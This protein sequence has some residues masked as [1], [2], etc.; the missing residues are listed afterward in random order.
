M[1]LEYYTVILNMWSVYI[2][3]FL[4][5]SLFLIIFIYF[6]GFDSFIIAY[7]PLS[8]KESQ[9]LRESVIIVVFMAL[10]Q[11]GEWFNIKH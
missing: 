3:I 1:I 5:I 10:L 11:L 2:T 9:L 6:W 7:S 8:D 4:C